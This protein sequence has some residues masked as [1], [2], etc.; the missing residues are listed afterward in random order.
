MQDGQT[1]LLCQANRLQTTWSPREVCKGGMK[2]AGIDHNNWEGRKLQKTVA[3]G[4]RLSL[5]EPAV[6]RGDTSRSYCRP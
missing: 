1:E 2:Q 5:Q 4:G 3:F 6:S